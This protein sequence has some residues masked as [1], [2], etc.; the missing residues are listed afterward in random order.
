MKL[1]GK[2][3]VFFS[4]FLSCAFFSTVSAHAS[5]P[6]EGVKIQV[7]DTLLNFPEVQPVVDTNSQLQVPFR[8]LMEA[9]GYQISWSKEGREVKV[10]MKKDDQTLTLKTGDT[11]VQVNGK[12]VEVKSMIGMDQGSVYL[13]LRFVSE[14]LGNKVQWDDENQLAIVD[15][16]GKY[17][18]P[19]WYK[20][21]K[22]DTILQ[23]AK[24]YLGVP[25]K[26]GGST[27][28]GFDCSGF[29]R[30]VFTHNR[31]IDLPRTSIEMYDNVGTAVAYPTQ[32][33]LVFFSKSG[34]SH[35]GIYMGNGQFISATSSHGVQIDSLFSP[36]WGSR[37]IGAKNI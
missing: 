16:D 3:F 28:N 27:P 18:A 26:W 37:Y 33:D 17:H 21:K 2:S 35:V 29:V 20:S 7:N 25:Y 8:P 36:Y 6:N 22:Q 32:G 34:V 1:S 19:A 23:F 11:F 30:Y 9:L 24:E 31:G 14:T 13:P 12:Q 4:A 15:A 10:S 5:T